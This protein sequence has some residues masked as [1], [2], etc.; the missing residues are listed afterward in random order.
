MTLT[1]RKIIVIA[2]VAMIFVAGNIMVIANWL[3]N[4]GIEEKANYIRE[5]FLTGTALTVILAFLILLVSP[6]TGKKTLSFSRTCPVCDKRLL[7]SGNY[8]SEC[9]SKV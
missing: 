4:N 7:G 5:Q 3:A 8:C 1:T 6:K 2:I 9:G